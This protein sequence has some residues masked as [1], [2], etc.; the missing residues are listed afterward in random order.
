MQ[1]YQLHH[2]LPIPKSFYFLLS[3]IKI[4]NKNTYSYLY[5]NIKQYSHITL[6]DENRGKITSKKI[7]E[8]NQFYFFFKIS[9]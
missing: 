8:V 5:M 4:E 1:L 9:L 7:H 2:H 3:H 6:D